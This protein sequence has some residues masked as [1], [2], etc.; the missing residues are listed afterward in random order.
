M[1]FKLVHNKEIHLV[2]LD[3]PTLSALKAHVKKVYPQIDTNFKLTYF[4]N[5]NDEI[6]LSCQEDLQVLV[7]EAHQAV[8][9]YVVVPQKPEKMVHP[10]HTCD[11]CQ[12]HPIVGARFKCL[13]CPDYD[14]CESCQSKNIHNNHKSF[15]ISN[16]EELEDFQRSQPKKTRPF[17]QQQF[18]H[19]GPFPHIFNHFMQIIENPKFKEFK[20]TAGTV[21][22]DLLNVIKTQIDNHKV[23]E[24][25][26]P[27]EQTQY[28]FYASQVDSTQQSKEE[29][30]ISQTEI[31]E[32]VQVPVEVQEPVQVQE[33]I[34][35][36][37]EQK[38][39]KLAE[40][41]DCSEALAR[42]YVEL[43]KELPLDEI[44]DIIYNQK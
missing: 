5:E 28:D 19:V 44:V 11:G 36:E 17:P 13:E 6:S 39:K 26:T 20:E 2:K 9:L 43:F 33:P 23:Q 41:I 12:K 4:D 42:E 18:H 1:K 25:E 3:N 15:K 22:S 27:Q 29:P 40:I 37:M 34:D 31:Q 35:C 21:A 30:C 14:L 7:D 38:I 8:K 24:Q 16:F 10:N 32:P